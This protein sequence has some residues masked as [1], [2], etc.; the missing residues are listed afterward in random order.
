MKKML[1][2]GLAIG[3]MMLGAL[4]A[5]ATMQAR[6]LDA[7]AGVDA[8]FDTVNGLSWLRNVRHE[9]GTFNMTNPSSLTWV[10]ANA[11]ATGL[12]SGWRLPTTIDYTA[13]EMLTL[14]NEGNM[15]DTFFQG[16]VTDPAMRP[17]YWSST[18]APGWGSLVHFNFH[19][20]PL[21]G[22]DT[23]TDFILSFSNTYAFAVREGDVGRTTE[24]PPT[25]APVPEPSTMLLL[26]AGVAGL[27][28]WRKRK[29]V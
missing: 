29:T 22:N 16:L 2:A 5:Q 10:A 19:P 3:V 17:V 13:G 26:G 12:G 25:T 28:F 23:S 14:Y 11:W 21:Q 4:P 24:D 20:G 8:Y 6:Y 27:A 15:T 7:T 1:L 9:D 18:E